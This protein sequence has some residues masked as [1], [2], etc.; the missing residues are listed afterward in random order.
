MKIILKIKTTCFSCNQKYDYFQFSKH[1]NL[2]YR[3][4]ITL[5]I[6]EIQ[7]PSTRI[8]RTSNNANY[9]AQNFISDIGGL[10]GLFLGYSLLTLCE[11]FLN[12]FVGKKKFS[13]IRR[14][15]NEKFS[16]R[17]RRFRTLNSINIVSQNVH[18]I[19]INDIC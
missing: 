13:T 16:R 7:F 4:N 19:S 12:I 14:F 11:Y 5:S 2:F 18:V 3:R 6:L 10:M 15:C 1:F 9:K 17:S 8:T